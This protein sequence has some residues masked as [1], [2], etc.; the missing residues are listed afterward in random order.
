[1]REYNIRTSPLEFLDILELQLEEK[2][3][4]HGKMILSG[5]IMDEQE[6]EY[7]GLLTGEVWEQVRMIGKDGEIK[8]LFTGIVTDFAITYIN[9]QKKLTLEIMT[10]SC[11]LDRQKHLRTYQNPSTI[12]EQIFREITAGYEESGIT[13]AKPYAETIGELVLQ[14]EETD[15]EFLKRLASRK[16]QF[17]IPDSC[18]KGAKL[19][20]ALPMQEN[21]TLPEGGKYSLKKDLSE[22]QSKVHQGMTVFG[23]RL[24]GIYGR[25]QRG[26]QAWRLYNSLWRE[27]LYL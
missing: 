15:W 21:F 13:F 20:Y 10:G 6:E 7:L 1:M 11:L 16:Q 8:T 2:I 4:Q 18:M 24:S 5:H 17:L 22:Y 23:S 26:A 14:Y 27:I 12:Y 19:F 9:D 3:N 25:M